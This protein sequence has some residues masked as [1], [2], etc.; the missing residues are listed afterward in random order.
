M[1]WLINL[2][3]FATAF[4]AVLLL[5]QFFYGKKQQ[6]SERLSEIEK[7]ETEG[8]EGNELQKPF[9]FR[10]VKPFYDS[11]GEALGNLTPR[12]IRQNVEKK[13]VYSGNPWNLTFNSFMGLVVV[14]GTL[15]VI[16]A[17]IVLSL[18]PLD[19]QRF[20]I[21]LVLIGFIGFYMPVGIINTQAQVRQ[22]NIQRSLPDMLDLLLVS[23]EAGLGFDMALKRVSE[24]MPGPLSKELGRALEEMR[25]G[26]SREEAL[27]GIV[28]RSGVADLSSFITSVIQAE[29]LG[30]NIAN[31]L[32]IQAGSMRQ[33]RR[34]RAEETAM[35]APIKMLFPLVFFIF[36]TLFVVILGPAMISIIRMFA[37]G[38]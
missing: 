10:V 32:R 33:K 35:K 15:L 1:Y 23:V 13:L 6:V 19:S 31:T 27:R 25:R 37:D 8:E 17:L 7:M 30:A 2:L 11:V 5:Y 20:V 38:F 22:K 26:K 9:F 14:S 28:H 18:L 36:P 3:V 29:Q 16:L 12:E 4:L 34:Q 21:L 24:K